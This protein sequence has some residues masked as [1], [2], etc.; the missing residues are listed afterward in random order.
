MDKFRILDAL[1]LSPDSTIVMQHLE[2]VMWGQCLFFGA[3][4]HLPDKQPISFQLRFS[5]C[6]E[7]KWQLY[8]HMQHPANPAFPPSELVNFRMG[9]SQHRSPAHLLTEHF[10]LSLFYGA[11]HIVQDEQIITLE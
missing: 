9:R 5:D 4:V 3:F 10:G 2:W 1:H 6:R 7:M 11:I 8:T